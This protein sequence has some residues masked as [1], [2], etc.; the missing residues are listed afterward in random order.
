MSQN[1]TFPEFL[2]QHTQ[3]ILAF[4][5]PT[6]LDTNGGF[7]HNFLDDGSV[8]DEKTRHLVSS[9][10]FVFNY[11]E[12]YR[13]GYGDHY[14][15]WAKHGLEYIEQHHYLPST[16]HYA[17]MLGTQTDAT[18]MAYGH[19]FVV[20]AYAHAHMAGIVDANTKLKALYE[21]LDEH[22]YLAEFEA[23]ADERSGDL[24]VLDP[25]R[26]QKCQYAHV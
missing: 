13:R 2:R 17:W 11:S 21:W 14:A 10:R 23:Y 16:N 24:S 12:A 26:G 8:F 19:A 25:Y 15:D 4:Y 7:F 9:T 20:L 3:T 6:V 18:A 5:E 1:Y 22:F